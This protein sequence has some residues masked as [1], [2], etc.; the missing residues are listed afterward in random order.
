MKAQLQQQL[1]DKYP[2]IFRQKD[3]SMQETAMCWGFACGDGW[4]TL[5]DELCSAIQWRVKHKE[6]FFEATQVKEKYGT[7][8][9]YYYGGD[10]YIQ[11][12]VSMAETMSGHICE[13]C[14]NTGK[15]QGKGWIQTRCDSCEGSRSMLE[16]S[17][18]KP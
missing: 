14:G 10:D 18:D 13:I 4:Y 8:C 2:K 3:L 9:F 6:L 16:K 17:D 1:F 15:T 5:I 12:L 7:L 11:G